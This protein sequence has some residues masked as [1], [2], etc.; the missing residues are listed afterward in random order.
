VVL[1][2][3]DLDFMKM[4]NAK[5]AAAD[6]D[7]CVVIGTSMKVSPANT[8]PWST[9]NNTLVYYVD[10]GELDFFIPKQKRPFFYHIQKVATEGIID[11]K[12][13]LYDFFV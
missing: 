6:C 7:V 9:N 11:I 13:D 2:G 8:I 3:E 1:F 10:P 5:V 12:K 4:H